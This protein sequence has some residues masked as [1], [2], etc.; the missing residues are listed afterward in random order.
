MTEEF[1]KKD[2]KIVEIK[3]DDIESVDLVEVPVEVVE[4]IGIIK[5]FANT[6]LKIV[7]SQ[8]ENEF[9]DITAQQLDDEEK[10]VGKLEGRDLAQFYD[11]HGA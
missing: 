7:E 5:E 10:E 11:Y 8:D 1:G 9:I 6:P 3:D 4:G 2:V